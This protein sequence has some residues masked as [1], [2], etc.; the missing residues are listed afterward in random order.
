MQ[1]F[2]KNCKENFEIF[3]RD[4][5]FYEKIKVPSPALCPTCRQQRRAAFRNENN[6]YHDKCDKTGKSIIS[7][8]RPET[9]ATVYSSDAWWSDSWDPLEYGRNFDF[10]RSFFEQFKELQTKVPR[11]AL[12][13]KKCENSDFSNHVDGTKNAYLCVDVAS[14]EDTYYSKWI[15]NCRNLVDCYQL[16]KSE[17]CYE[18]LYSVGAHN[19]KYIYLADNSVDSDFLYNCKNVRNSIMCW[20]L[21]NKQYCIKNQQYSKEDYENFLK[22]YNTGSYR[23]LQNYI[24]EFGELKSQAIRRPSEQINCE[25]CSGDYLYNCKNVHNSFGVIESWDSSYCYDCGWLKDCYDAY[26]A[27]FDCELQ[28]ESHA[29]NRGKFLI[30]CSISYDVNNCYYCE[31]CHNSSNLFGCIGLRHKQYCILNKQ[32]TKKEYELLVPKIIEH[33]RKTSYCG[34]AGEWGEFFPMEL[35]FFAYNESAAQEFALMNKEQ[36]LAKGWQWYESKKEFC[37][38]TC[39]IPDHIKD[40]PDSIT[41]EVLACEL[42]GRNYKVIIQELNFYRKHNLPIPRKCQNCRYQ[43]RLKLRNPYKLYSRKCQKC[44]TEIE[45]TYPPDSTNGHSALSA[46][47]AASLRVYCE[48]CYLKEIY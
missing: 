18:A 40:V 21:R 17:Q 35:S 32:Y 15:I 43:E 27:G 14:S 34:Q 2:C 44:R 4:K 9:K 46:G 45:T 5:I 36:V 24:S 30:G 11:L 47:Q 8:Y 31:M 42:C 41:K 23:N 38:Q 6:L 7:M 26:E 1:K 12:Y 3:S 13:S 22:E 20:N 39:K 48:K 29:C 28:Y 16:E 25:D 10:N 37:P 33:M 19:A